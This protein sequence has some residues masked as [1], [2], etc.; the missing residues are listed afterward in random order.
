MPQTLQE[1]SNSLSLVTDEDL[2]T[3]SH[4]HIHEA[5]V[6]VPGVWISR[7]N[8]QEHLTAIRSPVF[9]GPGS[10]GAFYMAEN[11][12]PLRS[13]GFCN[14]NQLFDAH[15]EQAARIEVIRGPGTVVHGSDAL[16]GV[17]NLISMPPADSA[18]H[19]LSLEA[20]HHHFRRIK[21]STSTRRG[22]HAYRLSVN[23]SHDGGYKENSGYDQHKL[24]YHHQY[25]G[26]EW[27]MAH[28]MNVSHLDQRT[29]GFVTGLNA[30]E[31]EDLHRVNG[32][33]LVPGSPQPFRDT[34]SL[35]Y[36]VHAERELSS[37]AMLYITPYARYTHMSFL[38]HFLPGTPLEKNGQKALGLQTLYRPERTGSIEF[39]YGFD[40][41]YTRAF[42][43]QT[44]QADSFTRFGTTFPQGIHYDYDVHA[45]LQAVFAKA[46]YRFN[47]ETRVSTGVRYEHISFDYDNRAADGSGIEGGDPCGSCRYSRPSD[48]KDRF[49]YW[50][51]NIGIIHQLSASL[52]IVAHANGGHR[53]PQAAELYRLQN[54]QISTDLEP[55][56][57]KNIEFG[58]RNITT[59]GQF[60]YSLNAFFMKKNDVLFQDSNRQNIVGG[61][62]RHYGLEYDLSWSP[63]EQLILSAN[64][65]YAR[66]SYDSTFFPLGTS[67]TADIRGNDA[68]TAPR[69]IHAARIAWLY[70]PGGRLELEWQHMG[71]Y[72]LDTGNAHEYQGHD[73]LHLRTQQD[74]GDSVHAALRVTNLTDENFADRADFAFGSYRYFIGEPRSLYLEVGYSW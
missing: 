73:L 24:S 31:H 63:H 18:E 6:R 47:P 8:G 4:L 28:L 68:D 30:F 38:Q 14:V 67:S 40:A 48:R 42:L 27:H 71:R 2:R 58:I 59:R 62:T 69:Q 23:S 50:S 10:C 45:D 11:G 20:G 65:S 1:L 56:A 29:A 9:T 3:V 7:G 54:G 70:S 34:R 74:F 66:H 44:Q 55:E 5:L 33:T 51:A 15:T 64:G 43:T 22:S 19:S 61:Q 49:G 12:V 41:E 72:Y 17:I 46:E 36:Q 60:G 25:S 13:T 37:G 16:H 32:A 52:L 35:R 53:A 39:S 57:L 26:S 21:A